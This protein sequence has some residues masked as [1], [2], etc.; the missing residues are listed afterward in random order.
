MSDDK[1]VFP[2]TAALAWAFIA[3]EEGG[4]KT[5]KVEGDPGGTTKW[6]FAQVFN[7]DIDVT[8]LT[9]DEARERFIEKY[10]LAN[11]CDKLPPAVGIAVADYAFNAGADDAIPDLQKA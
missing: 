5:H 1:P 10:W 2:S 9:F 4:G 8:L 11:H 3:Q 6:G 7:P